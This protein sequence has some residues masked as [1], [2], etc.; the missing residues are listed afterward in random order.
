MGSPETPKDKQSDGDSHSEIGGTQEQWEHLCR[1]L[2]E[3]SVVIG[4]FTAEI[5][6][7]NHRRIESLQGSVHQAFQ[8]TEKALKK[9]QETYHSDG[10]TDPA[11]NR[12]LVEPS[13]NTGL[14]REAGDE[15][16]EV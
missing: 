14:R 1:E 4:E 9:L 3:L 2:R 12:R 8:G 5:R 6:Q 15:P 13:W 7:P 10:H 11:R 16:D